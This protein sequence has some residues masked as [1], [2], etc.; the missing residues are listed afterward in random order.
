VA[1]GPDGT[2]YVY[3]EYYRPGPLE[4]SLASIK[5]HPDFHKAIEYI[6]DA[7]CWAATQQAGPQ[8]RSLADLHERRQ[9]WR[10][11]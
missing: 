10:K 7:S 8:V 9:R 3:W 2:C 11:S 5:A 6:L 1:V 4:E